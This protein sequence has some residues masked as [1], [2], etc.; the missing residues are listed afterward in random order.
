M[1]L[2]PVRA[3]HHSFRS[4]DLPELAGATPQRAFL[5]C[6]PCWPPGGNPVYMVAGTFTQGSCFVFLFVDLCVCGVVAVTS[7]SPAVYHCAQTR[8]SL[9]A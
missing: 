7:C 8:H 9:G 6:F 3:S 5:H 2:F 1:V 4:V